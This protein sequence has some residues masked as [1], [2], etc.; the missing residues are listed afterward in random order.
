M[1]IDEAIEFYNDDRGKFGAM[2]LC[3]ALGIR[4]QNILGWRKRGYIP[5]YQQLKIQ[6]ITNNALIATYKERLK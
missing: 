6:D 5:F 4:R 1:T 2:N 3:R